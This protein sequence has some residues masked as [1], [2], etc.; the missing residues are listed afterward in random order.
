VAAT[1]GNGDGG[2][3]WVE[4][5]VRFWGE[6]DMGMHGGRAPKLILGCRR[7]PEALLFELEIKSEFN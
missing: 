6:I 7:S 5:R 3:T 1:T 2:G 4:A